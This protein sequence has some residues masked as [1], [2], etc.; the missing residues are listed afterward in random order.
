[1]GLRIG[2][3]GGLLER[4]WGW[5]FWKVGS[6]KGSSRKYTEI[7]VTSWNKLFWGNLTVLR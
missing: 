3:N 7:R 4:I 5:N 1:M 2:S 6:E